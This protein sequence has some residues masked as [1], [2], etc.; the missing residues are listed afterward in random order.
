MWSRVPFCRISGWDEKQSCLSYSS[1]SI[2]HSD[3]QHNS[4]VYQLRNHLTNSL[5]SH[6]HALLALWTWNSLALFCVPESQMLKVKG[7][8]RGDL[9]VCSPL[10][11]GFP[12]D[13]Q[14]QT[15]FSLHTQTHTHTHRHRHTHT[16]T[17]THTQQWELTAQQAAPSITGQLPRSPCSSPRPVPLSWVSI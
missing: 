14:Q 7:V 12:S 10:K 8:F 2:P 15:S 9:M 11:A 5:L 3:S 6:F 17:H 13:T 4:Q 16:H 1:L